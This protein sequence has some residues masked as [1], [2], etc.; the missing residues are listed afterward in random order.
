MN[1]LLNGRPL[2]TPGDIA[3]LR[4]VALMFAE[5]VIIAVSAEF[6]IGSIDRL[7]KDASI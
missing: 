7:I 3:M 1:V 6:S 4:E 5:I 2:T